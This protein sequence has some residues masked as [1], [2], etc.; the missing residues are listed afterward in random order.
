MDS[1]Y[2]RCLGI[3]PSWIQSLTESSLCPVP[4]KLLQLADAHGGAGQLS[5]KRG[6][7]L[8]RSHASSHHADHGHL[9]VPHHLVIYTGVPKLLAGGDWK[10]RFLFLLMAVGSAQSAGVFRRTMRGTAVDGG[11]G[12]CA[13]QRSWAEG[14]GSGSLYLGFPVTWSQCSFPL[15]T[16]SFFKSLV[17]A[18]CVFHGE[19]EMIPELTGRRPFLLTGP[20][21]LSSGSSWSLTLFQCISRVFFFACDIEDP[22]VWMPPA[23][24]GRRKPSY[25]KSFCCSFLLHCEAWQVEVSLLLRAESQNGWPRV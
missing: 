17:T 6:L 3:L 12:G 15:T 14:L 21:L 7:F 18:G 23:L 9:L 25:S 2:R 19:N 24:L 16:C 20:G 5:R 11:H 13:T 8:S 10:T 22:E 4:P 1:G